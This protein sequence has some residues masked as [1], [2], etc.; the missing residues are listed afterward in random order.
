MFGIALAALAAWIYLILWRGG[1]W[2][3]R[4]EE[5]LEANPPPRSIAVVI[6]ARNEEKTLGAAVASLLGQNYPGRIQLFVVDDHSSDGT[7]QAAGMHDRLRVLPARTLPEGWT[8]KLWA[9]SEG[10]AA[11][12]PSNPDYVLFTDADIVHFPLNIAGL[13]ARAEAGGLDLVSNM[14]ELQCETLA[15]RA[16]IPAFV[17][18]FLMLYP[19][20]WIADPRRRTAGAAGGCIL[21]RPPALARMGGIASIRGELIDDCAL[22]QAIKPG[23]RLWLGVT[24]QARSIRRYP[25]FSEIH[26]MIA[27]T[28]FVQLNRSVLLLAGTILAMAVVYL[29]PPF[30]AFAASRW[31]ALC[32]TAAWGLMSIC[33]IPTLR[34]YRRSWLWAPLLPLVAAFYLVAT[35]D[36]ARRYW[37]G[38]G[39]E[40]KG[41]VQDDRKRGA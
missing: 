24:R 19:P 26:R 33:Y 39:G 23:G 5:P 12:L 7:V 32:G 29:A 1:F 13:V 30:L 18:F 22:A 6:P 20:R 4:E 31:T 16:L 8:G 25:T 15:E 28:A 36:S 41:R 2:M 11:A 34:F 27:R 40:W 21:I 17:F 10:L 9:L 3:V 37:L 14:V 38:R 35:L